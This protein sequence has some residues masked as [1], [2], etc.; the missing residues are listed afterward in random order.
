MANSLVAG[1]VAALLFLLAG[2]GP[3]LQL[4]LIDASVQKPSNVAVYFTVDTSAGDPVPGLQA[5]SFR[6]YE[7]D[8]LV[9]VHESQQTILNPEVAAEH[10]TIL[11]VDMSGSV[12]ESGDVPAVVAAADEFADRVG[13]YQKVGVFAFDGRG[14]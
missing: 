9:S 6:I 1:R 8:R 4:T 13:Q 7:D 14:R 12:T 5:D 10:F 3:G 11:L 2:C